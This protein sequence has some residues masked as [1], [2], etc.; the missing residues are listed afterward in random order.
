[1]L[2]FATRCLSPKSRRPSR[3]ISEPASLGLQV[4]ANLVYVRPWRDRRRASTLLI[5]R[6]L[7]LERTKGVKR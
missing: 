7:T 2:R 6:F 1:M 3:E 5:V 4:T